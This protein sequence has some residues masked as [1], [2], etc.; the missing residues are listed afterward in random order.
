MQATTR[1]IFKLYSFYPVFL[2]TTICVNVTPFIPEGVDRGAHYGNVTVEFTPT[3]HHFNVIGELNP[4]QRSLAMARQW[5]VR[6]LD[7]RGS[8][9][10]FHQYAITIY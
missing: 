4:R 5:Q 6:P 9:V 7:Q 1:N 8:R 3:F 10:N 2:K